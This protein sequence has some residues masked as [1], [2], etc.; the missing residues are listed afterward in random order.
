MISNSN[1]DLCRLERLYD[2]VDCSRF[3]PGKT[4]LERTRDGQ[5]YNWNSLRRRRR[6]QQSADGDAV[7]PGH[8]DIHQYQVRRDCL[9][10]V[11]GL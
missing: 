5:N 6:G 2:V 10:T 1:D 7:H 8:A 3:K 9:R 4:V 11:I